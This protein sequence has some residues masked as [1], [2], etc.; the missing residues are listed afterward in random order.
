MLVN[1]AV[2]ACSDVSVMLRDA[3]PRQEDAEERLRFV[4]LWCCRSAEC[5]SRVHVFQ[6][7]LSAW[8][9]P[10]AGSRK[11]H[12][13]GK[14]IADLRPPRKIY[15]GR[16]H[17]R[18]EI[19]ADACRTSSFGLIHGFDSRNAAASKSRDRNSDVA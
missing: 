7:A 14:D 15:S 1:L 19:D 17:F 18:S 16:T 13:R 8:V 6:I 3:I 9:S 5:P 4:T 12:Q 2:L 10:A 11:D